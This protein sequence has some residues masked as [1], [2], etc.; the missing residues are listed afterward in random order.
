MY[1]KKYKLVDINEFNGHNPL[2]D[3]VGEGSVCYLV[4]LNPGER[5]W[6]MFIDNDRFGIPHRVHTSIVKDVQYVDNHV[7]VITEN[8]KLMFRLEETE[9]LSD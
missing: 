4:Y 1:N 5:G 6:W 3:N 9:R 8:T 2:Y 7:V